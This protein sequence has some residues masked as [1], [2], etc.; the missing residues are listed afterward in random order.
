MLHIF[1]YMVSCEEPQGYQYLTGIAHE[2]CRLWNA[3]S[4]EAESST[5]L[6]EAHDAKSL[7]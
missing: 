5:T 3:T 1:E 4:A 7:A 6:S 2:A